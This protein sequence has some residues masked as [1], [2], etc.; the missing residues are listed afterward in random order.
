MEGFEDLMTIYGFSLEKLRKL[1][2]QGGVVSQKSKLYSHF[3]R[4]F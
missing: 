1:P 4:I 3:D 2:Q